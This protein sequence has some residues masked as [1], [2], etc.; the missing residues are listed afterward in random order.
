LTLGAVG[1]TDSVLDATFDGPLDEDWFT[2]DVQQA[3]LLQVRYSPDSTVF[4]ELVTADPDSAVRVGDLGGGS[5][6]GL[7]SLFAGS[8]VMEEALLQSGSYHLLMNP[9]VLG[10][11]PYLGPY[12]LVFSWAP[13]AAL[14]APQVRRP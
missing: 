12:Q 3:G 9:F 10:L 8:C 13:S 1:F 14:G 5:L 7:T 4:G 2:L 6:C 11:A